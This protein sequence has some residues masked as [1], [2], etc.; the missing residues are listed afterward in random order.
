MKK[1]K[2]YKIL[3]LG[4]LGI[5][6]NVYAQ[7]I[8][9]IEV[10]REVNKSINNS[11]A[12]IEDSNLP[13]LTNVEITLETTQKGTNDGSIKILIFTFGKKKEKKA[14]KKMSFIFEPKAEELQGFTGSLSEA[15]SDAIVQAAEALK[16]MNDSGN[17]LKPKS[18]SIELGFYI[19]NSKTTGLSWDVTPLSASITGKYDRSRTGFHS[20]KLFFGEK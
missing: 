10:I 12:I 19:T 20:V 15:L 7:Q 2:F 9:P 16:S 13:N 17:V 18:T 6:Q 8:T 14:T 1:L 11:K 3:I 5:I 4:L